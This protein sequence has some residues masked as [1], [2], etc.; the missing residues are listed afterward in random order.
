[1]LCFVIEKNGNLFFS[2]SFITVLQ[3]NKENMLIYTFN[4]YSFSTFLKNGADIYLV[5]LTY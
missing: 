5:R 1:M 4:M 3:I 2:F